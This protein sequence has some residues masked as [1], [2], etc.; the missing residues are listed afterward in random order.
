MRVAAIGDKSFTALWRLIGAEAIEAGSD[1]E[2]REH[3]AKAFKSREYSALII[4]EGL[5]DHVNE[6]RAELHAE[7]Q[8]E[9]V[10]IFVPEPGLGR[11]AEDLRRKIS[12]AIG[13]EAQL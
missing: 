13:I 6:V 3:L 10:I 9:P 5:L 2:V 7:E 11:R 8:I 4:S 12:L 1:D